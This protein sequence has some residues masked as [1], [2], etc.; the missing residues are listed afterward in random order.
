MTYEGDSAVIAISATDADRGI[1][2]AARS[3]N[4]V[5]V[6]FVPVSRDDIFVSS[7]L[8]VGFTAVSVLSESVEPRAL[9]RSFYADGV[10]RTRCCQRPLA[11]PRPHLLRR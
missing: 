10:R 2:I 11:P 1:D 3:G 5:S 7:L 6:I 4:T 9:C 8:P